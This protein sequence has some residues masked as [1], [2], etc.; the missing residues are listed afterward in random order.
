MRVKPPKITHVDLT[1]E[2]KPH[3]YQPIVLTHWFNKRKP[4]APLRIYL[5]VQPLQPHPL[6]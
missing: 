1:V 4:N 3:H 2:D 6:Y 5:L